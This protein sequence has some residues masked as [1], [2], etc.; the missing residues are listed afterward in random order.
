MTIAQ[1][2]AWTKIPSI[3]AAGVGG[4]YGMLLAVGFTVTTPAE[5][6]ESQ[7]NNLSASI[8]EISIQL[9]VNTDLLEAL[10]KINCTTA[11]AEQLQL[12]G[13]YNECRR[14]GIRNGN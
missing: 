11:T 2:L 7:R 1:A 4:A 10:I 12:S 3:V 6:V 13:L 5:N 8:E 9:E 14:L